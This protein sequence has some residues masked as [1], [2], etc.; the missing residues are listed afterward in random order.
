METEWKNLTSIQ[1]MVGSSWWLIF[2]CPSDHHPFSGKSGPQLSAVSQHSAQ[3]IS[4]KD[5][6]FHFVNHS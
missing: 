4:L 3:I 2:V 5:L 1:R 6:S